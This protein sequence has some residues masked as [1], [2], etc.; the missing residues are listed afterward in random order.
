MS[1][2]DVHGPPERGFHT[3]AV[4]RVVRETPDAFSLVFHTPEYLTE[5]FRYKPG[6]FL[7]LR[8][9][10]NGEEHLRCYSMSSTPAV[11]ED[12]QVTVKRVPG[13]IVSNWL[14]NTSTRR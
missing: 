6:Q 14:N 3:L 10:V 4:K 8:V 11:G 13:G 5:Q 7:T 1:P 9:V 12:L 2:V